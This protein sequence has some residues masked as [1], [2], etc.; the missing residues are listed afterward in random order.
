MGLCL[1]ACP[2]VCLSVCLSQVGVLPK[3]QNLWSN[4]QH[5]WIAQSDAKTQNAT[6]T[7]PAD[8]HT[9]KFLSRSQ[10]TVE[11]CKCK[12]N[13]KTACHSYRLL[14]SSP[15]TISRAHEIGNFFLHVSLWSPK[16]FASSSIPCTLAPGT[17]CTAACRCCCC[18]Y[19]VIAL[20]IITDCDFNSIWVYHGYML[21]PHPKYLILLHRA[22]WQLC[23]NMMLLT[24]PQTGI[25][26][27]HGH[28]RKTSL[29][30]VY[31][32][33]KFCKVRTSGCTHKL[34]D[35][36]TARQTDKSTNRRAYMHVTNTIPASN[37]K[38]WQF[39]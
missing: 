13:V 1:S 2:S 11:I 34:L 5:H 37:G 14:S 24:S 36:K 38:Q 4:K 15:S 30:W 6:A 7:E 35:T 31:T 27:S 21:F 19:D 29:P 26:K 32:H 3:R 16:H 33:G 10:V 18:C 28:R 39:L 12:L 8:G 23:T 17:L 9:K 20:C 25:T 22:Y